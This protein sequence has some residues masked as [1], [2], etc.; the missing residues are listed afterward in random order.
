MSRYHPK[1]ATH[2]AEARLTRERYKVSREL[3]KWREEHP[4]F[5]KLPLED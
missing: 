3:A 5:A 2:L 1:G 4:L